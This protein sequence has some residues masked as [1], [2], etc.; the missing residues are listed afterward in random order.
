MDPPSPPTAT[1]TSRP[2]RPSTSASARAPVAAPLEPVVVDRSTPRQ[3]VL[4]FLNAV[5]AGRLDVAVRYLDLRSPQYGARRPHDIA[6]DLAVVLRDKV[7]LNLDRVSDVPDGDPADGDDIERIG[8]VRVEGQAVPIALVR[9]SAAGGPS[10]LFSPATLGRVPELMVGHDTDGWLKDVLPESL[11]TTR[12]GL[13][14]AWQWIGLLFSLLVGY[15]VGMLVGVAIAAALRRLARHTPGAWDDKLL[16]AVR[17]TLRFAFGWVVAGVS[18]LSL[19]LPPTPRVAVQLMVTTPLIF[20]TG[21]LMVTAIRIITSSYL[22]GVT[23][24]QELHTRGIRT[25]LI[26]LRKVATGAVA[27]I[28]FAVALMQLEVVRSVGWSLL[29]SAGVAGVAFGFAA[30][31]SLGAIIAGMQ[32]SVTQPLRLGD[33]VV[34]QGQWGEVEEIALTYVRVKLWDERRFIV[35]VE[36]FLT[37]P[38]ENWSKPGDGMVGVVELAVDP[39][40]PIATLRKEAERYASAHP[41][42]D[43]RDV[44]VQ[45]T[46]VDERRALVRI[47]VTTDRMLETFRLRCDVREHLL[48][49]LQELDGG[50][51]L[52]RQ[53]W[54]EIGVQDAGD[55]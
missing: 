31:K 45:V 19:E 55:A 42:H 26:V 53:R 20:A 8:E 39:T 23:D 27:L 1:A 34:V 5:N 22:T 52:A 28:T 6:R 49:F 2:S 38:F 25:Q 21:W 51:Y 36:K 10:W 3:T 14:W 4:G 18:A 12:W 43:G 54:E 44:V 35:P 47:R 24:D 40:A 7:A 29:A 33:A 15:P 41:L 13:M 32:L 48:G 16:A 50:R 11:K 17:P 37:E 30:Q 9:V 46:D